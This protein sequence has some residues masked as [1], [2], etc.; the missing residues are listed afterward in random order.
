MKPVIIVSGLPRSGTS[1][2]MKML[3]AGGIE[4][5]TDHLRKADEDNPQ[6]YYEVEL[7]KHLQH[8][9]AWLH[10]MKGKAVKIISFLLY[11]L[12]LT[13]RYQIIFMQREM[14]EILMSQKKMLE[15][16]GHSPDREQD[17]S[18]V[19]RARCFH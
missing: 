17:D 2:M 1:M 12:P 16:S 13:L 7:V 15:R 9:S 4:I 8:D 3:A 14:Q 19:G 6:G 18:V 11:Y 5:H 10:H